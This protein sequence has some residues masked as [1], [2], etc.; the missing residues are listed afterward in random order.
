M[1]KH[2]FSGNKD[3]DYIILSK[4]NDKDLLSVCLVN[5]YANKLCRNDIFWKNRYKQKFKKKIELKDNS[6]RKTYLYLL[7]LLEPY[8]KNIFIFITNSYALDFDKDPSFYYI[9]HKLLLPSKDFKILS[10]LLNLGSSITVSFPMD[11]YASEPVVKTYKSDTYFSPNDLVNII[12]DFYSN[13][14]TL[15]EYDERFED[16]DYEN[17]GWTR[18]MVNNKEI[19]REKLLSGL[20]IRGV[21]KKDGVIHISINDW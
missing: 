21:Y 11:F 1:G 8:Q 14:L 6:W 16:L 20:Y 2:L 17:N 5:K 4:L 9:Y 3:V 13:P 18:E 12:E 15:Q 19:K 10:S 7:Q